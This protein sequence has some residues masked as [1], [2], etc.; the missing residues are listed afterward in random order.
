MI[1]RRI[2]ALDWPEKDFIRWDLQRALPLTLRRSVA[3]WSEPN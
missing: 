3:Q 1:A 2:R